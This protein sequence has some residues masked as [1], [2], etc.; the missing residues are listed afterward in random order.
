MTQKNKLLFI[1]MAVALLV[2]VCLP[3][4]FDSLLG[5][6]IEMWTASKTIGRQK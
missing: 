2:A 1:A 4:P 5:C 6:G 3:A